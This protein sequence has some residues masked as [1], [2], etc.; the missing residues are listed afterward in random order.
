VLTGSWKG[1]FTEQSSRRPLTST[2]T[3]WCH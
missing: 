2:L 1:P 3:T